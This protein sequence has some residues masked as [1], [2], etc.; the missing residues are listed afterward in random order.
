MLDMHAREAS[1]RLREKH[2]VSAEDDL[3]IFD[4]L[5]H[6][7]GGEKLAPEAAVSRFNQSQEYPE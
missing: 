6:Q 1:D 4:S 3:G 2:K 5:L 7:K